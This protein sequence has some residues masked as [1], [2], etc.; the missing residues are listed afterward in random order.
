MGE[1][2]YGAVVTSVP[3]LLLILVAETR[4]FGPALKEGDLAMKLS[5]ALADA[6]MLIAL[7]V[8]FTA[9]LWGLAVDDPPDLR[10]PAALGLFL[11]AA[12]AFVHAAALVFRLYR[13]R[14]SEAPTREGPAG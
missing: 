2:L 7:A 3:F 6:F 4:A 5:D 12:L 11:G 10:F 14:G 8:A 9:S 13:P 1:Q